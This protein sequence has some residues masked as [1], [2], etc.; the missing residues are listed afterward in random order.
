MSDDFTINVP[1]PMA[2]YE[3]Q[4]IIDSNNQDLLEHPISKPRRLRDKKDVKKAQEKLI[5]MNEILDN[6]DV[7]TLLDE[8]DH[9]KNEI[10]QYKIDL[11]NLERQHARAETTDEKQDCIN[12]AKQVRANII[13]VNRDRNL[14]NKRL[15]PYRKLIEKRDK[16]QARLEEHFAAIHEETQE[17]QDVM[18]MDNEARL[19]AERII[20]RLTKLKFVHRTTGKD[21][22]GN[23]SVNEQHVRFE[24]IICTADKIWLKIDV[25]RLG[26][27]GGHVDNLPHDVYA[28]EL[29]TK[30]VL[31]ELSIAL[32]RPVN[33]PNETGDAL[34]HQGVW[35]EVDRLG[36]TD[37]LQT[38]VRWSEVMK[39]YPEDKRHRMPV[40]MGVKK[41]RKINWV[42]LDDEPHLMVNGVTGFGKSNAIQ[43]F[44]STLVT[45]HSPDE[46]RFIIVDIKNTGDFRWFEDLPHNLGNATEIPEA[47]H[48]IER[49]FKEMKR[50]SKVIRRIASNIKIYNRHVSD[51]DKLPHIFFVFDEYP[52][53]QL[54]KALAKQINMYAA[55]IAMQGRAAGVH[56]FVSGQQSYA[57]DIPRLL[58]A[59]TTFKFTARQGTTSAAMATTGSMETMRMQNIKGRF[60][61]VSDADS[62]Q[63]QMP[64]IDEAEGDIDEAVRSARKWS[65]PRPF[66]LPQADT[67]PD[68]VEDI[69]RLTDEEIVLKSAFE[70]FNGQ[71]KKRDIWEANKLHISLGRTTKAIERLIQLDYVEYEDTY[72]EAIKATGGSYQLIETEDNPDLQE[73]A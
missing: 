40:P 62:Y 6:G 20:L 58:S 31:A 29:V 2:K 25:S 27:L 57:S 61:C 34:W 48:L 11:F 64:F 68:N 44:L 3:G 38:M 10:E 5:R 43:M 13:D 30:K 63:V 73:S 53:I 46:V 47:L 52:S 24:R 9:L 22:F 69:P 55:Q 71:L 23:R 39:R 4:A 21:V 45:K 65:E 19:V 56:M 60:L 42:Y 26:L 66:E 7:E 14:L 49:T 54:D 50:R 59:N 41:G 18:N 70:M 1:A 8:Y 36:L 17:K 72:Y 67:I 33:S 16:V 28:Q 35:Y 32:E 15:K 12:Q 51:E 37:G